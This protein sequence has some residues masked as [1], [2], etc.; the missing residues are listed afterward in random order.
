MWEA[1]HYHKTSTTLLVLVHPQPGYQ[2]VE[3]V[4]VVVE[5]NNT[6]DNVASADD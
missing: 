4:E 2:V 6:L 5:H 1:Q 3:V